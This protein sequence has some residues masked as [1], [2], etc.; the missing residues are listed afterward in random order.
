MR[1]G[2]TEKLL[3]VPRMLWCVGHKWGLVH[4]F[5]NDVLIK[6]VLAYELVVVGIG[7]PGRPRTTRGYGLLCHRRRGVRL[8]RGGGRL[9]CE[10]VSSP[11]HFVSTPYLEGLVRKK[12]Y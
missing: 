6:R 3:L 7:H 4:A 11:R 5:D 8:H 9:S 12:K 10:H 1:S 2:D